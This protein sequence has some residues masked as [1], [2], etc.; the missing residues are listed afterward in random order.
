MARGVSGYYG[1]RERERERDRNFGPALRG[2]TLDRRFAA[3]VFLA[4][5]F[6]SR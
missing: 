6:T 3:R 1:K 2:R 5:H 4:R